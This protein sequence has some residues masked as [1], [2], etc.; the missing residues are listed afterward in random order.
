MSDSG[1]Q[2]SGHSM[3]FGATV[4]RDH[5]SFRLFAP[6]SASVGLRLIGLSE[7]IPM[8]AD[9]SGWH[10]L[11]TSAA[12]AGSEYRYLLEDGTS[13]PDPASRYQPRDVHGPSQVMNPNEY[14][15][16]DGEWRGRPWSEAVLYELH[17]G[18]FTSKGTFAAAAEHLSHL[19]ELGVTA[20]ELMCVSD[21]A[22]NRNWGYDGVLL[23]APDSAYGP[24]D[25][26]KSFIDRAHELG[27]MVI[28]DV[29]YNH[30]GPE[31][32]FIPRYFPEICSDRHK[33]PWGTSLNF[34][35]PNSVV[36]RE[37]VIHNALYWIEEFHI[38]GL[39]LDA[40]HA[41]IDEGSPHILDELR[42][43][44]E[45]FPRN[46]PVY[47][48]LE[49]EQN[50]ACRLG[51]DESGRMLGY[52]AQWNHDMTHLLGAAYSDVCAAEDTSETEKLTLAL[53]EGFTI[54]AHEQGR[55][56]DCALPP[57]AFIAFLQ[58][59]D[60][61]GNRIFGDRVWATA[62]RDVLNALSSIHVLLPQIPML[63]MGEEWGASTPFPFFCDYH[64]SL[65]DDVRRG[66]LK[67]LKGQDPAPSEE[68]L[69]RS[70]DPQAESTFRSAQLRWDEIAQST[71]AAN[72]DWYKRLLQ[73][74]REYVIP[75]LEG[76][77]TQ[78]D[79]R[80]VIAPG[81]F[82]IVWRLHRGAV[83]SVAANLCKDS[84][85]GF[86]PA[87]GRVFWVTGTCTDDS[88]GPWSVRWA[89]ERR[90]RY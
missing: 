37:F 45:A 65:A 23:Y 43:R 29:V 30:F 16:S 68:D 82:S 2:G 40:S 87:A 1:E 15:W 33:T 28:L 69:K 39:R 75:L 63:F 70:P 60:L 83:L 11:S 85:D 3:P 20:V 10:E 13:V 19:V 18:T 6:A 57:T 36:V 50:I 64:G 47:L 26:M 73:A 24:P 77:S 53:G 9:G 35:G 22:G 12:S 31:G 84:R 25:A 58:T 90:R 59:H 48:I 49:N 21:F 14:V 61:V 4:E 5:V 74:R 8:Q 88:F 38:D 52:A 51:R 42:E 80:K 79:R 54:A 56:E 71:H 66:R 34:D 46:R 55:P 89:V 81:A 78:C 41:M 67:Q 27:L 72:L 62:G 76:L 44:V 32:D 17:I 86:P 7:P